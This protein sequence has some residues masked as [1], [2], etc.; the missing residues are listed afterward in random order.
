VPAAAADDAESGL[1]IP[2][3]LRRLQRDLDRTDEGRELISIWLEHSRE[4][5]HL[6]HHEPRVAATWRRADG[7]GLFRLV[8]NLV[9]APDHHVPREIRGVPAEH[10][11]DE[12]LREV[13]RYASPE[14][15]QDLRRH[16]P[17]LTN[18]PGRSYDDLMNQLH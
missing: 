16:R 8:L 2:P 10:V 3:A 12:F 13:E 7:P 1:E 6:V 5:N 4:L 17:L 14:L 11:L 15:R 18:L 9:D